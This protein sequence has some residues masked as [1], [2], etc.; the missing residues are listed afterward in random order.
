MNDI[1]VR[2]FKSISTIWEKEISPEISDDTKLKDLNIDSLS[3]I[4]IVVEVEKE[5]GIHF[6]NTMLEVD[7]FPDIGH[8]LRYIEDMID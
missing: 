1:K 4:Q 2:L 3:F 8:L 7:S 5:F 6:D